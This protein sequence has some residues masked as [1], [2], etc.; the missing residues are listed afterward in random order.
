MRAEEW[1][2][3]PKN[4]PFP[5]EWGLPGWIAPFVWDRTRVLFP[6]LRRQKLRTQHPVGPR[7]LR[8]NQLSPVDRAF[9]RMLLVTQLHR[10]DAIEHRPYVYQVAPLLV[11][12]HSQIGLI[13]KPVIHNEQ[14]RRHNERFAPLGTS[15]H[16]LLYITC[17]HLTLFGRDTS[18]I[19]SS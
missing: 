12:W 5:Q 3:R 13:T 15:T 2:S 6:K 4:E 11:S 7:K 9:H 10:T 1:N 17:V 19:T 18:T 16:L 14:P 8:A